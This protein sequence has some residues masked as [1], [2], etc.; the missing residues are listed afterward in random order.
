MG[1]TIHYAFLAVAVYWVVLLVVLPLFGA[2]DHAFSSISGYLNKIGAVDLRTRLQYF[3]TALVV[4]LFRVRLGISCSLVSLST[5]F[6][7]GSTITPQHLTHGRFET[8]AILFF[9]LALALI[10]FFGI[11]ILV[12]KVRRAIFAKKESKIICIYDGLRIENPKGKVEFI[13]ASHIIGIWTSDYVNDETDEDGL[14]GPFADIIHLK[15]RDGSSRKYLVS[16]Y[17]T[18]ESSGAYSARGFVVRHNP[19]VLGSY[20]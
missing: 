1:N 7:V 19:K 4:F 8:S 14:S 2:V 16:S 5:F 3:E 18:L 15:L 9:V 13:K 17:S 12:E 6:F 20:G 10:P 11:L